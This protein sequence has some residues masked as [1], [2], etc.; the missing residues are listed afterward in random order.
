MTRIYKGYRKDIVCLVLF[1]ISL[2]TLCGIILWLANPNLRNLHPQI[3]RIE[4][5]NPK[6]TVTDED[7]VI[8]STQEF[9]LKLEQ[10]KPYSIIIKTEDIEKAIEEYEK[11]KR[12]IK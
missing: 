7:M 2:W 5:V 4:L 3:T 12:G 1:F 9:N 6:I 11:G 8:E 10:G